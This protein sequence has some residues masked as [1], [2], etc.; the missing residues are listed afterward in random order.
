ML[1]NAGLR[2]EVPRPDRRGAGWGERTHRTQHRLPAVN[3]FSVGCSLGF[4]GYCIGEPIGD[5]RAPLGRE[6]WPD[7]RWLILHRRD[8]LVASGR[9]QSQSKE[10]R[11]GGEPDKRCAR[12]G[13]LP[14]PKVGKLTVTPPGKGQSLATLQ[15]ESTGAVVVGYGVHLV[16]AP[17]DGVYPYD[18]IGAKTNAPGFSAQWNPSFAAQ[19]LRSRA[20]QPPILKVPL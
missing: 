18:R 5:F 10:S 6:G 8:E 13:G 19:H 3:R 15:V 17:V 1:G 2:G 7:Q 11:L 9:V 12:W 4:D 14:L 16:T 20:S